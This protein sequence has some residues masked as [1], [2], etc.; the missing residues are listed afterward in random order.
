M[1]LAA[2]VPGRVRVVAPEGELLERARTQGLPTQRLTSAPVLRLRDVGTSVRAPAV[3]R[4]VVA[5]ARALDAERLW[6]DGPVVSFSQWLHLPLA[7]AGRRPG[8][9]VVLDLHDGPFTCSGAAVQS[10]AAWAAHACVATSQTALRHLVCW[11]RRRARVV[12]RPVQISEAAPVRSPAASAPGPLRLAIVTRLDPEKRVDVA[13]NAHA[14]LLAAGVPA[15]LDVVGA[16]HRGGDARTAAGDG[17]LPHRW[18]DAR[19]HGKLPRA[20]ALALIAGA[21]ALLSTAPGEAFGRTVAEA[22]LLSVPSVVCGGG[23]AELVEHGRTGFV[24]PPGDPT[25]LASELAR[26]A[27]NRAA[28]AQV[29]AAARE[30]VAW[31]CDPDRVARQWLA[32]VR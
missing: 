13:L 15:Q 28:L 23:P 31:V 17:D 5:A 10:A 27:A 20:A 32:A 24:V 7:L 8:R 16:A 29:G 22:A 3:P 19:F 14:R 11:P 25:A 21:D 12:P 4:S 30:H 2:R 18:P 6:G 26:L 1:L 9:R